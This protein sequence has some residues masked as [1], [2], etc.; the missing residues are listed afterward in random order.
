[1]KK[2]G[3][4][5]IENV[6]SGKKY[7]GSSMNINKRFATHRSSLK[8]N[9][10]HCAYLQRAVNKYGIDQFKFHIIE[11]TNFNTRDQLQSLE[12]VYIDSQDNLYNV[13][14]VGGGDN[15]TNNPN[16]DDIILRTSNTIR[17]NIKRMTEK[18]RKE[19]WGHSG[20]LNGRWKHGKSMKVI[21][22]VCNT[23]E[24]SAGAKT[25]MRCQTYDRKGAKNSFYGKTHSEETLKILRDKTPWTKGALPEEQP[26]TKQ[27][28][29]TYP[30]GTSKTVYGLKAIAT[31]FK[32]S[33]ANVALTIERMAKQ[34]LP[35]KRSRFYQ[36]LVRVV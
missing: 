30:D 16:R 12:Q 1:M 6:V 33:I 9:R 28:E 34:S 10:H 32:T 18:E 36:H 11:E 2:Q 14:S 15:L 22:P 4:Y 29:I 19:K 35:T 7:I 5:C 13:G 24:K 26:Y 20:K 3:I 17:S 21:C 23:N 27:Y 31:E 25:C 8:H